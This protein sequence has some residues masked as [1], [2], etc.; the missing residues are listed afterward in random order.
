MC[1][2]RCPVAETARVE[3]G[4]GY[5]ERVHAHWR[6]QVSVWECTARIGGCLASGALATFCFGGGATEESEFLLAEEAQGGGPE[7]G[8]R[9][10][11]GR[12]DEALEE[13]DWEMS[14]GGGSRERDCAGR[15]VAAERGCGVGSSGGLAG[16]PMAVW[17]EGQGLGRR[18]G[19]DAE[20]PVLLGSYSP[21]GVGATGR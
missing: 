8:R 18:R 10:R 19:G 11:G 3:L 15:A 2:G 9:A 17:G 14:A 12:R 7:G 5:P 20:A 6:R 16:R 21:P 1:R 13:A 4:P